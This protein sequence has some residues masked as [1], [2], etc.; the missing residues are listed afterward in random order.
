MRAGEDLDI[1][2]RADR[3]ERFSAKTQ[4]DDAL[5]VIERGELARR[6]TFDADGEIA[7]G[8]AMAV[9][10]DLDQGFSAVFQLNE[11]LGGPGVERVLD[12]LFHDARRAL[13][14]LSRSDAFGDLGF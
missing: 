13:D 10:R 14:D 5:E 8:D 7:C 6:V 3:G 4:S 9:V 11:D 2:Y 1:G 12:E